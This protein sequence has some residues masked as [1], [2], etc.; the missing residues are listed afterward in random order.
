MKKFRGYYK[1]PN[2]ETVKKWVENNRQLYSKEIKS[3]KEIVTY[4]SKSDKKDIFTADMLIAI[5]SG[6]K[7]TPKM[8]NAIHNII[9]R[10]DPKYRTKRLEWLD[11]TL[12]KMNLLKTMLEKT[13]WKSSYKNNTLYFIESV[14]AQ[15][16]NRLS[17]TKKQ[18]EA[19]NRLYKKM[20]KHLEKNA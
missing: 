13:S 16:K 2:P 5:L 8:E 20:D 4:N 14:E 6:R 1:K 19:L 7:I 15:A 17:L 11:N 10:N 12:P 18:S 3:L 9:K